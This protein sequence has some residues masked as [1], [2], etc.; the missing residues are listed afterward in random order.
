MRFTYCPDCGSKL[1]SKQAG[2][3]GAV[4]YCS[5]CRKYWFD[6]FPSCVI[7]LIYNQYDEIVLLHQGYLSD[8]YTT[9]TAGYMVPGET[10]EECVRREIK[11]ELG[12][13]PETVYFIGTHWFD[14][15]EILMHCFICYAPKC[16]MKLSCEVD[17]AEWVPYRKAPETMF[18]DAPGNAAFMLYRKFVEMK[19]RQ[20]Q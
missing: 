7:A 1:T 20:K 8:V 5:E 16:E 18:P 15:K 11:E 2:D 4:P 12:I 19:E 14:G 9:F 3:D 17:A 13:T 6:V 10:A